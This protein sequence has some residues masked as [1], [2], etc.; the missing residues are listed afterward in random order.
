MREAR[1]FWLEAPGRGVLRSEVLRAP[2]EGEIL[3][4]AEISAISRGTESLVFAGRVPPSQYQAMRCPF[5]VG[6]FPAP[7]KYGAS[8]LGKSTPDV[9]LPLV[10]ATPEAQEKVRG[11]M[12]LAGVLN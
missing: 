2:G 6:E 8:L 1:A 9:R 3:V 10:A 11:A 7:V 12:R 5:Q 4:R